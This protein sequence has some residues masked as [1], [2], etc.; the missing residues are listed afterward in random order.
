MKV[1]VKSKPFQSPRGFGSKGLTWKSE[2]RS[3]NTKS[4]RCKKTQTNTQ[5]Q[6]IESN[7]NFNVRCSALEGCVFDLKLISLNKFSRKMKELKL[8]VSAMYINSCQPAIMT[9]TS[10]TFLDLEIMT[11]IMNTGADRPNT[12][13]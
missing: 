2:G 3:S 9:E 6:Y 12:D 4:Y 10:S 11:V 7:T 5:G 13:I 1:V 8:Y